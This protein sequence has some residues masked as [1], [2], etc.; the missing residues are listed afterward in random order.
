MLPP[1]VGLLDLAPPAPH[2]P[3]GR[4]PVYDRV[5]VED[6]VLGR[7]DEA[8]G[9]DDAVGGDADGVVDARAGEDRVEVPD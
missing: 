4:G 6:L 2:A 7:D 9:A 1:K 3:L 8:C 5:L